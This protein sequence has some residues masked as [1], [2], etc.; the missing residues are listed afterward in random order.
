MTLFIIIVSATNSLCYETS[1]CGKI[2]N[3]DPIQSYKNNGIVVI[4]EEMDNFKSDNAEYTKR[5]PHK[6]GAFKISKKIPIDKYVE[7]IERMI[8][9][10][11]NNGMCIELDQEHREI[12][13]YIAGD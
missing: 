2:I 13:D 8:F 6:V 5:M 1:Y 12:I 4:F 7:L 3:F 11:G 10:M 9:T